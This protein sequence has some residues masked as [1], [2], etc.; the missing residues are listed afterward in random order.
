MSAII[1][2]LPLLVL[3]TLCSYIHGIGLWLFL[4]IIHGIIYQIAG[5]GSEH[6]P[7]Y[8]GLV[9]VAIVLVKRKWSGVPNKIIFL[10][11]VMVM[12]MSVAALQGIEQ[13]TGLMT[14]LVYARGFMLVILLAGALKNEDDMK[15]MTL[16]C[17]AGLTLGALAALYQYKTGNYSVHTIYE[18]RSSS[19]RGDPNDTAM[20]L[21]AGIPFAFYWLMNS[22]KILAKAFFAVVMIILLFG[23]VLTGSRGG[24]V[25]LLAI[26]AIM[27]I[28][29]PSLKVFLA[30]IL[31]SATF[32][33][34]APHSYWARMETLITR[35]E[36]HG[37]SSLQKRAK[38]QNVGLE[39]WGEHPILGVGP[40]N[41]GIAFMNHIGGMQKSVGG[42]VAHNMYL[43]FFVENGLLGGLLFL[44]IF[45]LAIMSALKFDRMQ[46]K[47]NRQF[48]LGFSIAL[49]LFGMLFSGLFLSQAKNSVLWFTTGMA[50]TAGLY[51]MK[52]KKEDN[53]CDAARPN[54]ISLRLEGK[55]P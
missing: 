2:L 23:I 9:L 36:E 22:R 50:M 4:M 16:Y 42:G 15:I 3:V 37:G 27:F 48:G 26:M 38:L 51:S 46:G 55:I 52:I 25:A 1:S 8:T 44:Y 39:I 43:E 54:A 17:L 13:D 24:F 11:L 40:G 32:L 47:Q 14:L 21:V 41:F 53:P 7:F 28:R 31:L 10:F 5:P 18:Q 49:A 45:A 30:G 19:L 35:H 6:L 20:L 33:A 29:R 12:L 34:L